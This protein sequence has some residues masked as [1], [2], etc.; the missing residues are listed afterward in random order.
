MVKHLVGEKKLNSE[1]P[2]GSLL[3]PLFF[4]NFLND[5]PDVITLMCKMFAHDPSS[6]ILDLGK[7]VTK[8]NTSTYK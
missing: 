4:L 5:L 3:G 6:K 2:Q 1:V 8:L 7:S